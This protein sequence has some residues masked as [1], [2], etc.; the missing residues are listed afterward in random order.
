MNKKIKNAADTETFKVKKSFQ[1]ISTVLNNN[2]NR[3]QDN[4]ITIPTC[5]TQAAIFFL[6][7]DF[8]E[9]IMLGGAFKNS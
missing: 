7:K 2:T 1:Q 8:W 4:I 3:Y 5:R 6:L 9:N